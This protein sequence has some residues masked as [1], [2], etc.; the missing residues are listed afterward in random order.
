VAYL[1]LLSWAP[2]TQILNFVYMYFF[3]LSLHGTDDHTAN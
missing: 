3:V 1:L 2:V